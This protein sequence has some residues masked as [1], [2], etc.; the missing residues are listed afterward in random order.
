MNIPLWFIILILVIAVVS[1]TNLT[2]ILVLLTSNKFNKMINNFKSMISGTKIIEIHRLSNDIIGYARNTDEAMKRIFQ[3]IREIPVQN[4]YRQPYQQPR[5]YYPQNGGYNSRSPYPQQRPP[6]DNR[7]GYQQQ[8]PRQYPPRYTDDRPS[9]SPLSSIKPYPSNQPFKQQ[10]LATP[11]NSTANPI[12][13]LKETYIGDPLKETY[14]GDPLKETYIG[15][16]LSGQEPYTVCKSTDIKQQH[17]I[18]NDDIDKD[19]NFGKAT[20]SS[21]DDLCSGGLSSFDI[22]R[23]KN[24]DTPSELTDISKNESSD[25]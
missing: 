23:P 22:D 10:P 8:P 14:I 15:D 21:I 20:R 1:I 13:P 3:Y 4:G 25:S 7:G 6:Y 9:Q 24:S 11:P 18:L 12:V 17:I 5:P 2:I 16:P 19:P